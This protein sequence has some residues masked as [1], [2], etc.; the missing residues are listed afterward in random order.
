MLKFIGAIA[1]ALTTI[2]IPR[3]ASA[4]TFTNVNPIAIPASGTGSPGGSPAAPYPSN[5]T[6]SGLN[7]PIG[8]VSITLHGF[9]HTFPDDVDVLLVAPDGA[10]LIVLS[11]AGDNVDAVGLNLTFTDQA[12]NRP[13][14][15]GAFPSGSY[16]PSNYLTA[17][18]P[19]PAPAPPST[20]ADFPGPDGTATFASKFKGTT[21]TASGASTLSMT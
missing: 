18:D 10:K 6:V 14:D 19:F 21:G 11:D 1:I 7:A 2:G 4:Q 8:R 15:A 13:P 20:T 16:R 9:S 3:G 17:L 5:I 12:F